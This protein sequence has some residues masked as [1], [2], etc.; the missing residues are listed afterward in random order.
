M[1]GKL[2][3]NELTSFMFSREAEPDSGLDARACLWLWF[4]K[5]NDTEIEVEIEIERRFGFKY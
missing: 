2:R 3:Q 4:G 1:D 5:S